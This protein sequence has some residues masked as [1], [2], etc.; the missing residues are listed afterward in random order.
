MFNFKKNAF[1]LDISDRSIKLIA[2]KKTGAGLKLA[3]FGVVAVRSGIIE[4]GEIKNTKALA[5]LVQKLIEKTKGRPIQ[6][7]KVICSLPEEKSFLDVVGLPKMD[8]EE[9]NNALL[10]EIENHIPLPIDQVYFDSEIIESSAGNAKNIDVLFVA[11]PKKI[12]DPYLETLKIAGLEPQAFEI[13]CQSI[14]RALKGRKKSS[15]PFLIID[16]GETRTTFIIFSSNSIR[17]TST[18]P[19]SSQKLT[20]AIANNLKIT[21]GKAEKLKIEQGLLK[22]GDIFDALVP[23]LTDLVEQIKTHI[24]YYRS[25][26]KKKHTFY[27]DEALEKILLCGGGAN[28][29][30]LSNFLSSELEIPVSVSNTWTNIQREALKDIPKLPATKS[31]CYTTALGLALRGAGH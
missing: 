28:L 1:G 6:S 10:Y 4:Q 30:G 8:P 29:K 20:D 25:H 21:K 2:L 15:S 5:V 7:K 16:F 11:T 9:V 23:P 12:V 24:N 22:K 13:E 18:I 17:F 26:E 27:K 19:I 3:S 14:A 31:L